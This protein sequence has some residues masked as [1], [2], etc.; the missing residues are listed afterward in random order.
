LSGES[1]QLVEVL[2]RETFQPFSSLVGKVQT[3]N[4]LIRCVPGALYE[5]CLVRPI[6]QADHAVMAKEEI[7][8]HFAD[9]RTPWVGVPTDSQEKLMLCR[10]Q[11]GRFGLL[12]APPLKMAETGPQ[13]QQPSVHSI[14]QT[15]SWH[16]SIL[17][18]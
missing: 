4:S 5:A 15:Q 12:L 14:R 6:D 2:G 10:R 16:D 18:R 13:R 1:L 17:I 7:V 11:P 8:R 3:N 9:R